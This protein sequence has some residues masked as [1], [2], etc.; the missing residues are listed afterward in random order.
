MGYNMGLGFI[1]HERWF[2]AKHWGCSWRWTFHHPNA[3]PNLDTDDLPMV[4]TS[5]IDQTKKRHPSAHAIQVRGVKHW[6]K[7]TGNATNRCFPRSGRSGDHDHRTPSCWLLFITSIYLCGKCRKHGLSHCTPQENNILKNCQSVGLLWTQTHLFF[8]KF[9][10]L[11]FFHPHS[12]SKVP[13]AETKE[14]YQHRP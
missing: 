7:L 13:R 8:N 3:S 9:V 10:E 11:I 6:P 14:P 12:P 1:S 2:M 5:P 4:R